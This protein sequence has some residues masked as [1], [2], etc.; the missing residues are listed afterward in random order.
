[1]DHVDMLVEEDGGVGGGGSGAGRC[2]VSSSP[3]QKA[4]S[5]GRAAGV[6]AG[7]NARGGGG[8]KGGG[9]EQSSASKMTPQVL[10]E[11]RAEAVC[12]G[13]IAEASRFTGVLTSGGA[14]GAAG[15]EEGEAGTGL[16]GITDMLTDLRPFLF[17]IGVGGQRL[18]VKNTASTSAQKNR[19]VEVHFLDLA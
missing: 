2:S 3:S 18:I 8:K 16:S 19:R 10:S 11:K 1:M 13:L 12:A 14:A 4:C 6:K 7:G 9:E 17:P 15:A 5:G